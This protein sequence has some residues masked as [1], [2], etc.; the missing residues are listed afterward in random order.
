MGL[1][2]EYFFY[3]DSVITC[4]RNKSY[5]ITAKMHVEK[6]KKNDFAKLSNRCK[7]MISMSKQKF[8]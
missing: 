5:I 7:L 4:P 6:E 2:R 8:N 3:I 1:G